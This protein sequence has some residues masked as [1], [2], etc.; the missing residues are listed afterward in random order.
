MNEDQSATKD[1]VM[2][3]SVRIVGDYSINTAERNKNMNV[4]ESEICIVQASHRIPI[5]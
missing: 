1:S 5:E 4:N 2:N 3:D